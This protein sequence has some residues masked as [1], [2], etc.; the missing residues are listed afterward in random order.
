MAVEVTLKV[1]LILVV[2]VV[3]SLSLSVLAQYF[4]LNIGYNNDN[5]WYLFNKNIYL[6]FWNKNYNRK[7]L[8]DRYRC[9]APPCFDAL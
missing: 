6:V 2:V 3:I 9:V 7:V 4:S 1:P 5:E 8:L